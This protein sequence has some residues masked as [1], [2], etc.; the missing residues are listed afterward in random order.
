MG[1]LWQRLK[2]CDR[3]PLF[4]WLCVVVIV[5]IYTVIVFNRFMP[6]QEGWFSAFSRR[7]LSGEMPYRD[8]KLFLQPIYPYLLTAL[9][10]VFG[11]D[12]IVFRVY[13]IF[14]RVFLVSMVY[15]ISRRM[16]KPWISAFAAIASLALYWSFNADAIY[17]YYQLS[18]ACVLLSLWLMLKF[19]DEENSTKKLVYVTLAGV[20]CSLSFMVK[21]TLGL[22]FPFVAVILIV[23]QSI[24]SR[25]GSRQLFKHLA[26]F[27]AAYASIIALFST[28]FLLTNSFDEY[29]SQVYLGTSSKGPLVSILFGS[30]RRLLEFNLNLTL[31]FVTVLTASA[32]I[33]VAASYF[34]RRQKGNCIVQGSNSG[35]YMWIAVITLPLMSLILP[36][37][38]LSFFENTSLNGAGLFDIKRSFVHALFPI[39]IILGVF[40]LHKTLFVSPSY[41]TKLAVAATSFTIIYVHGFSGVIEEPSTILI[42]GFVVGLALSYKGIMNA[43]KQVTL[44]L[45]VSGLML[46]C[47]VQRMTWPYGWWGWHE[48]SI[49]TATT[50]VNV[51]KM[52]G[53]YMSERTASMYETIYQSLKG[54]IEGDEYLYT[55]P[56]IKAFDN[57]FDNVPPTSADVHYF[58]VCTDSIAVADSEVLRANPPKAIVYMDLP[59]EAWSIHEKLFRN[60]AKSGQREIK[61]FI[62]EGIQSGQYKVLN[63]IPADEGATILVLLR[64]Q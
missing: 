61:R 29:I 7:I 39:S 30:I 9:N 10:G 45:L 44:M 62:D 31:L 15:L 1:R 58:D 3:A 40:Y 41:I 46:V 6:P 23:L 56:H 48:P 13:G 59:E 60:G 20:A 22:A 4:G 26:L 5:T 53:F 18:V 63:E 28:F 64:T 42:F 33:Y 32:G 14:E 43:A 16:F 27:T 50:T 54:E 11:F 52:W 25:G 17:S 47:S 24:N 49:S 21:Q 2:T 51:P 55:F 36:F 57:I 37:F 19:L 12:F 34:A 35:K 8:F 38:L